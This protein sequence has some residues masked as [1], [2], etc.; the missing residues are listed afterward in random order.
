MNNTKCMTECIIEP[1]DN[2]INNTYLPIELWY[3]I[4]LFCDDVD[5]YFMYRVN[6]YFKTI[7]DDDIFWQNKCHK[8]NINYVYDV[9]YK[10][11]YE[12]HIN[13]R[14]EY[15]TILSHKLNLDMIHIS[16]DKNY[17]PK[18]GTIR[19]L[20]Y[21]SRKLSGIQ[22]NNLKI[23]KEDIIFTESGM[24][25]KLYIDTTSTKFWKLIIDFDKFISKYSNINMNID[26][27]LNVSES[28]CFYKE[29]T[30]KDTLL[31]DYQISNAFHKDII[32]DIVILIRLNEY[33]SGLKLELQIVQIRIHK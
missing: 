28:V 18:F 27:P 29:D 20:V 10:I 24:L 30:G 3:E 32:V 7:L 17:H 33:D 1:S 31:D 26:M 5:L 14:N 6:K 12:H 21:G 15:T 23:M 13:K 16:L 8:D 2:N 9:P 19:P 4:L 22:I 25:D 11:A